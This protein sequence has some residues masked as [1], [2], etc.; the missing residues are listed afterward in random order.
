MKTSLVTN[1]LHTRF[2][3]TKTK[4]FTLIAVFLASFG[5]GQSTV[6]IGSGNTRSSNVPIVSN[7]GYSYSE[8]IYLASEFNSAGGTGLNMISK[9]RFYYFQRP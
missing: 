8:N 3:T 5:W 9:I 7:F 1:K 6:Q 4:L 2:I